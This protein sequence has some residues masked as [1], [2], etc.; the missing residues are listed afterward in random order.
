MIYFVVGNIAVLQSTSARG[1]TA[2]KLYY[3]GGFLQLVIVPASINSNISI[4]TLVSW[5]F[6]NVFL[7]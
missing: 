5:S 7:I 1:R 2:V 4:R 3:L 6:V